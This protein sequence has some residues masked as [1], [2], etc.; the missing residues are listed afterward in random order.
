MEFFAGGNIIITDNEYNTLFLL[1]EV[2]EGPEVEHL[3]PGIK[4]KLSIRQNYDGVP[5]L[6][7]ERVLDGLQKWL[8][9]QQSSE[10]TQS[11]SRKAKQTGNLRRALATSLPE[12]PP[13]LLDHAFSTHGFDTATKVE[14]ILQNEVLSQSLMTVLEEAL[15]IFTKLTAETSVKGFI[16][17]KKRS[18]VEAS[19]ANKGNPKTDSDNLLYEQFHPFKARQFENQADTMLLEYDGFNKTVDEFFS[20]LEGQK[21]QSRLHEREETAKRRLEQARGEHAKRIGGLQQA[22]A[23]HVRKAQAIEA[24]IERVEEAIS[25]VN[26]LIGQGM[27]WA[28]IAGLIEVEQKRGNPVAELIKLPLK[29]FENTVTLHLA[30]P[31]LDDINEDFEGNETESDDYASDEDRKERKVNTQKEA[32]GLLSVDIDLGLSPWSNATLYYEQKKEATAKEKKTVLASDK[33]LKNAKHKITAD[34]KKSLKQEKD[35]LRPVRNPFW[36]EKF[37]YFISSDGYLILGYV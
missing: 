19:K 9:K 33:A 14:D 27:D 28:E 11:K 15:S 25:A 3:R 4:Y 1:R 20:S 26:G 6:T 5:P 36:F 37:Y 21:L 23:L 10:V 29:L 8:E 31:N 12:F 22:Q 2:H 34:L 30:I 35:V 7:K 32:E 17:A 18:S 24:D 16:L 13:L